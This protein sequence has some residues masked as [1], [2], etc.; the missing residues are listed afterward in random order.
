V[1]H[2]ARRSREEVLA[3]LPARTIAIRHPE[4]C[5]VDERRALQCVIRASTAEHATSE[6]P[7]IVIEQWNQLFASRRVS[8]VPAIEQL[9]NR[10]RSGGVHRSTLGRFRKYRPGATQVKSTVSQFAARLRFL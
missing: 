4:V 2:R 1:A 6:F 10:L 8:L 5:L 7:Q 9:R 3:I